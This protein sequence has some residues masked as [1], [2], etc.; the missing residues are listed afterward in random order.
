MRCSAL[1]AGPGSVL[2]RASISPAYKARDQPHATVHQQTGLVAQGPHKAV[3]TGPADLAWDVRHREWRTKMIHGMACNHVT[4][5][6][7]DMTSFSDPSSAFSSR[8]RPSRTSRDSPLTAS[9]VVSRLVPTCLA[10]LL[11]G[12]ICLHSIKQ[13]SRREVHTGSPQCLSSREARARSCLSTILISEL[14]VKIPGTLQVHGSF[15]RLRPSHA[16]DHCHGKSWN[17]PHG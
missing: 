14:T 3:V 5:A 1:P 11:D 8:Q 9:V 13:P 7:Y 10:K 6:P 2:P 17:G 16:Q 4:G 15:G 12:E